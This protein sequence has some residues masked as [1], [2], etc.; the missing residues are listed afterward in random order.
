MR[1]F[2]TFIGASVALGLAASW[3]LTRLMASLLF[4]VS[5]TDLLT[6]LSISSLLT[7]VALLAC[8]IPARRAT[9]VDP[10]IALRY[11]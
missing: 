1:R 7:I 10:I 9:K 4:G 5:A 8:W 11:E 6:F 3:L 2:K